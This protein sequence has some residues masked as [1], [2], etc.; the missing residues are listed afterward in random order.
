MTLSNLP[1]YVFRVTLYIFMPSELKSGV[2]PSICLS[3]FLCLCLFVHTF[4]LTLLPFL[5]LIIYI[6]YF[7]FI[8]LVY[9]LS[10]PC[11]DD[12]IVD[13][14]RLWPWACDSV[15]S[16]VTECCIS[17]THIVFQVHTYHGFILIHMEDKGRNWEKIQ[18]KSAEVA[19]YF[20]KFCLEMQLYIF[21]LFFKS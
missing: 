12:I 9:F 17:H 5:K 16:L 15:W 20:T 19:Y 13:C 2:F 21:C 6:R 14:L 7:V 18:Q 4:V 1:V 10:H 8:Q 3:L 11:L